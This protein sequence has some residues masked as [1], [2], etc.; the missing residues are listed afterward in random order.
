MSVQLSI[1]SVQLRIM[2]LQLR[3][4]RV[5]LGI[6]RLQLG[7]MRLQL[8]IMRLQL[9][10]VRSER[11][12][13]RPWSFRKLGISEKKVHIYDYHNIPQHLDQKRPALVQLKLLCL[14]IS[15]PHA[16]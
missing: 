9:G 7:I 10:I 11:P 2:R 5:Q 15:V 13:F 14:A 4:M 12:Q 1:M 8:G 6:M 3:I 16:K